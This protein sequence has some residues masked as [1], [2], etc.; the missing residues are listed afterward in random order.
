MRGQAMANRETEFVEVHDN[1]YMRLADYR[2][3]KA[4]RLKK[5]PKLYR[6]CDGCEDM[7]PEG[8]CCHQIPAKAV[9]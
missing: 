3:L 1:A 5:T 4:D 2:K 7:V 8:K 9:G 6:W